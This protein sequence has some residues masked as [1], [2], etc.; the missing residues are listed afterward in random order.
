MFNELSLFNYKKNSWNE[1]KNAVNELFM[2]VVDKRVDNVVKMFYDNNLPQAIDMILIKCF[3]HNHSRTDKR[4]QIVLR[5]YRQLE[6]YGYVG[7]GTDSTV[8]MNE[9]V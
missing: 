1:V 4:V 3:V 8:Q 7:N 5:A 2:E 6:D 9:Q